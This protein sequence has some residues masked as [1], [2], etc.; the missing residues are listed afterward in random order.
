MLILHGGIVFPVSSGAIRDGAVVVDGDVIVGCGPYGQIRGNFDGAD[1]IELSGC[2][3]LPGM[4]NAHT[5]LELS[6]L[7]GQVAYEGDFIDWVRRLRAVRGRMAGDLRQII[8]DAWGQSV[9]AGVTTVGDIC[10]HDDTGRH[11]ADYVIRKTAFAEFFGMTAEQA[12]VAEQVERRF[13]RLTEDSLLRLGLSPHAPY[14]ASAGLYG[15]AAH[16]AKQRKLALT[17]HLAENIAEIEFLQSGAGP[18]R[19]YLEELGKWD[20][21]FC[22]PGCGPVQ[23]FLQMDLAGQRFALAHVN[24]ISDAELRAL[25]RT[26][27]SVVYC[28]R[29]QDFFGHRPHRF[30]E[31]LGAGVNVCLGTD[32]LASNDSLSILD[33]VRF[34][35]RGD[36]DLP[37]ETL[38]R[39]AT[40]NG[41]V[42]LGWGEQT[43][44]IEPSK[45][46]DVIALR[47]SGSDADPLV[48]IWR[49]EEQPILTM[50]A[51]KIVHQS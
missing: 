47:L 27:H 22:A 51:G 26:Q 33:E 34:L 17:T 29:S 40:V 32:S 18:W 14:S 28:P 3:L 24:C 36:R 38:L 11:L 7:K 2:A 19:E 25:A 43:G 8:A 44:T 23:Y 45:Q 50:V 9:R 4:V 20:G 12:D 5:H 10:Y 48:D 46:A 31:M 41:A 21:S 13:A 35:H 15:R 37:S 49:S 16:L 39:M 42:A 30:V 1:E 6:G